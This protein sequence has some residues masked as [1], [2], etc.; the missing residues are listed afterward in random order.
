MALCP[1]CNTNELVGKQTT[2]SPACRVKLSRS[3]KQTLKPAIAEIKE[4]K[5][6]VTN[7]PTE[8]QTVA[9]TEGIASAEDEP[10]AGLIFTPADL[11]WQ[12]KNQKMGESW[13]NWSE[14]RTT[15]CDNCAKSFKTHLALLGDCGLHG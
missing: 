11:A 1:V 8:P 10:Q 5:K 4:I 3:K 15:I 13:P 2:C 12:K 7:S 6:P 9:V 14:L